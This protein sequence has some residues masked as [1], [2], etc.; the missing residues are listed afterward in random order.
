MSPLL[1]LQLAVD[2]NINPG[3]H[4]IV[5]QYFPQVAE[6]CPL[7][8]SVHEFHESGMTVQRLVEV[9]VQWV[10]DAAGGDGRGC[11]RSLATRREMAGG[12]ERGR[13]VS[14]FCS[15]GLRVAG[16]KWQLRVSRKNPSVSDRVNAVNCALAD[17]AGRVKYKIHPRCRRLVED[18]RRDEVV[19]DGGGG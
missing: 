19:G 11:C 14:R 13:R 5:G 15:K 2:F 8:T 12:R 10:G 1:P 18:L 7:I 4:A 3:M 17:L 16:I 9:F 6:G